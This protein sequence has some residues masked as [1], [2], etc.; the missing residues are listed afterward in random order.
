[1]QIVNKQPTGNSVKTVG[2][3]DYVSNGVLYKGAQGDSVLIG[4]ETD[5]SAL[6]G[7]EPGALAHT[8]GWRKVW[9]LDV[10]GTTWVEM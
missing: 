9:E 5:L 6:E 7:Y 1:M 8:A 2:E 4:S 3:M 10:D